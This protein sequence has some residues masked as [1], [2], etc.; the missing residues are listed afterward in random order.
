[1]DREPQVGVIADRP[2]SR[3]ATVTIVWVLVALLGHLALLD[4]AI[5]TF[6]SGS[7][8]RWWIAPSLFV[9]AALSAWLWRPGGG[10][11]SRF[12]PATAA[13][14]PVMGFL[15]LLAVTVWLP[16]GQTNGARLCLQSTA[17]VLVTA[18]GAAVLVAGWVLIRGVSFLR[19]PARALIRLGIVVLGLYALAAMGLALRDNTP[20]A[21]LFQGGALWNRLPR[22]LQGSVVG[23][24]VLLPLATLVQTVRFV[25]YL[26]RQK[27]VLL[28]FH[29]ATAL[30][31][32]TVIALSGTLLPGT[33]RRLA[34]STDAGSAASASLERTQGELADLLVRPAGS[35]SLSAEQQADRAEKLFDAAEDVMST[36]PRDTF[37]VAAV[38]RAVGQ[39]FEK[40]FE[41][42]RDHTYWVPYRGTLRG[43]VGVLMDRLGNSLDRSLLLVALLKSAGATA[44]LAHTRLSSE[45]ARSLLAHVRP[46]PADPMGRDAPSR[47]AQ[48][49]MLE[50]YAARLGIQPSVLQAR[51]DE[52]LRAA[53]QIGSRG[54]ERAAQQAA[55][56]L[57]VADSR[58]TPAANRGEAAAADHWW[59]QVSDR[60]TWVDL[61]PAVP[62]ARV[63]A[64]LSSAREFF[65][66]E[67]LPAPYWQ[68]VEVRVVIQQSI[69]G[70]REEK[71][72]LAHTL[73]PSDL[74]GRT[75][76][77]QQ[78]PLNMKTPGSSIRPKDAVRFLTQSL[79]DQREWLPVLHVGD[80]FYMDKVVTTSGDLEDLS[81][82]GSGGPDIGAGKTVG[83]VGGI[84]G[85]AE[86]P[87]A[88]KSGKPRGNSEPG[89]LTGEWIEYEIR[90]PDEP[91]RTIRREI[92]EERGQAVT[93]APEGRSPSPARDPGLGR[94]FAMFA[95]T[96]ILPIGYRLSPEFVLWLRNQAAKA[97]RAAAI[98]LM[99]K[100]GR[101]SATELVDLLGKEVDV[102][103]PLYQL[104]LTRHGLNPTGQDVFLGTPN[105][106]SV[107][108]GLYVA[109]QGT[110]KGFRA[111]DIVANH[112]EVRNGIKSQPFEARVRQ[113]V[114]DTNAE[115]LVLSAECCGTS[116]GGTGSVAEL[117][118]GTRA[119]WRLLRNADQLSRLHLASETQTRI[120]A[121][122][123]AGCLVLTPPTAPDGISPWW[124]I[125]PA[126]GD[127][128]GMGARGWGTAMTEKSLLE[129]VRATAHRAVFQV[130]VKLLLLA[131]CVAAALVPTPVDELPSGYPGNCDEVSSP[132]CHAWMQASGA[133]NEGALGLG[134][135]LGATF[136]GFA[137]M[138]PGVLTNAFW[139]AVGTDVL[140]IFL[141][142]RKFKEYHASRHE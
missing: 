28:L 37:D 4:A 83:N 117:N 94:V 11:L 2:S 22:W 100:A 17:T 78:L 44:R 27:P 106:L 122:L 86:E 72:A 134:L 45:V 58:P 35:G 103:G 81:A 115:T 6:W 90:V 36:L 74:Q 96:E 57:A 130:A 21:V 67:E 89:R 99:R 132:E 49:L 13:A 16:A 111:F 9:F 104:A 102:P 110:V 46:V 75:V 26:R 71:I 69:G 68:E 1:M 60:N 121:D 55:L 20:F 43:P 138:V 8:M 12:G 140:G 29:Q 92:F 52:T 70:R 77:L 120:A 109:E 53:E 107:H 14:T 79:R 47:S 23:S 56:L 61:D 80:K 31:M 118:H 98:T 123:A 116:T 114:F 54:A 30:V 91:R 95:H 62:G 127:T 64:T 59:V 10:L 129:Y 76:G 3:S 93:P 87:L 142:W 50:K 7:P 97:N 34:P 126:T 40:L 128:L 125:D 108:E 124:R 131:V 113:G 24:L 42:V 105:V 101:L 88:A 136:F 63:G 139:W 141:E 18:L 73:R 82:A 84:L 112:V 135:C 137:G 66:P 65:A 25:G 119:E 133:G 51:M 19:S 32:A 15:A 85:G 38:V 39:D 48:N 33:G 5:E 41:W